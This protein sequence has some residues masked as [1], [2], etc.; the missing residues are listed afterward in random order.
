MF[1]SCIRCILNYGSFIYY[2]SSSTLQDRIE[3]VQYAAIRAALGFR[4]ST[5]K[6]IVLAEARIS[7][8]S[9][10]AQFLAHFY[11][12][13]IYSNSSYFVR[14]GLDL[15]LPF[16]TVENSDKFRILTSL[17]KEFTGLASELSDGPRFVLFRHDYSTLV[18]SVPVNVEWG[19]S[20][21]QEGLP[22]SLSSACRS[23]RTRW[24]YSRMAARSSTHRR[25]G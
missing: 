3:G 18:T 12:S 22:S 23:L 11:L 19:R 6:N 5:P 10:R 25:L 4:M 1:K 7:P 13:K 24:E 2:S 16:V 21:R 14:K 8:I 15:L 20:L 17:A 9:I